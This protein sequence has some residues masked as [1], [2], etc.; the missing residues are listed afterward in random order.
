MNDLNKKIEDFPDKTDKT[1]RPHSVR[2]TYASRKANGGNAHETWNLIRF[3]PLQFGQKVPTDESAWK[4]LADLKDIVE[5]VVSPF[6]TRKSIAYLN[7]KISEHRVRFKEVFPES[8]FLPKHHLL[9]A[10]S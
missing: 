8:N 4:L 2:L 5:V 7:F 3:F 10:L 9:G 1:N 6:Q